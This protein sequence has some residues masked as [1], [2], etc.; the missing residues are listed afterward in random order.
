LE[1]QRAVATVPLSVAAP[2]LFE[3]RPG[4]VALGLLTAV[5]ALALGL[6]LV[7]LQRREGRAP[8]ARGAA[9]GVP[10][11][12]AETPARM[13]G[14]PPKAAFAAASEGAPAAP[15]IS[16]GGAPAALLRTRQCPVCH[17][18]VDADV[19]DCPFC[20]GN[21]RAAAFE[22]QLE[23]EPYAGLDLS[24]VRAV[25]QRARLER[26]MGR[27]D[28]DLQIMGEAQGAAERLVKE[29]RD[30]QEWLDRAEAALGA[31]T[32]SG[33]PAERAEAYLK[34]ARSLAGARAFAKA[35]R[36]AERAVQML[37]EA[38]RDGAPA[39]APPPPASGPDAEAAVRAELSRIREGVKSSHLALDEQAFELLRVA[40][41]YERDAR[42]GEALEVLTVLREKL[43]RSRDAAPASSPAEGGGP[44]A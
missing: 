44:G 21:D 8:K 10:G 3:G 17:N 16:I 42:W 37:R 11:E 31:T 30:G 23:A 13:G 9:A 32:V 19:K 43:E 12:G 39:A 27:H 40:E 26:H 22:A 38:E 15:R 35:A 2:G 20:A 41:G 14:P 4:G 1:G 28:R 6:P 7:A 18:A 5:G 25:L 29:R 36:H 24:E 34:L 33:E